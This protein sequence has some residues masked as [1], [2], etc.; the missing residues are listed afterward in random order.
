MSS[1]KTLIT[2]ATWAGSAGEV[3]NYIGQTLENLGVDVQVLPVK[4]VKDLQNYS[5][6][7]VGSAIHASKLHPHVQAFLS[8]N[9]DILQNKNVAY[10]IVCLTMKD[11]TEENRKTVLGY[12]D[13][14][15]S[16]HPEIKPLEIG[17]FA[18]EL[19]YKNMAFHY[20]MMMK[21]MKV[22]EADYRDW[23]EIRL[24]SEKLKSVFPE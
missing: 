6:I 22:E 11:D 18:G 1:K 10:F 4:D 12:L 14:I 13:D 21:A 19:N 7:I 20:R 24:W 5:N 15:R 9:K 8:N 16:E 23:D 3:A 2:Y 17:L